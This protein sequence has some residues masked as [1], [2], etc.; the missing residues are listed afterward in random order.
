MKRQLA[1]VPAALLIAATLTSCA[2]SGNGDAAQDPDENGSLTG[3]VCA[4]PGS[5][6]EEL[7]FD[8][9]FGEPVTITSELPAAVSSL[10]K[11]TLISVDGEAIG[12]DDEVITNIQVF[13]GRDGSLME[14]TTTLLSANENYRDWVA[15][16][17]NCS[18]I[19]DRVA[20]VVPATDVFEADV[21]D[22]FG[23]EGPTAD[24]SLIIVS[25][26]TG[27]MPQ[28]AEGETVEIP[29]GLPKVEVDET[30]FPDITIPEG[31]DAPE[32]LTVQTLVK[33]EGD[34]VEDG[35]TVFVHYRGVIWDTG[36]EFDSSWSRGSHTSFNT[37]GVIG[38]FRE[39]LVGQTIGSRVLSIV[40]AEDG[41]YGA[42]S[43]KSMGHAEDAV[44]VFVLDIL[45]AT[46]S[47]A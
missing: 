10:E 35:A 40:P 9:D 46:P 17:I 13:N 28:Q 34:V 11:S 14:Q 26:F 45:W 2:T 25:D 23:S 22:S 20:V 4:E 8:G 24:D 7:A 44:M 18:N 32:K 38:G 39:A 12:N 30:G 29:D 47:A 42:E 6:S 41:G 36:E 37:A 5:V 1:L 21:L 43:L 33:G 31:V 19:G 27:T 16:S 3:V 15:K